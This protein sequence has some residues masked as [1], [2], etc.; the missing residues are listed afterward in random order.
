MTPAVPFEPSAI[1][2]AGRLRPPFHQD[3][4]G[5][6]TKPYSRAVRDLL[7]SDPALAEVYWS[8]SVAGTI[9]G[10]HFQLP[11]T[12]IGKVVFATAGRVRDVVLDLRVGSPAYGTFDVFELAAD[13][14]AVV[15]PR[16]CAHGFEVIDGPACLVYLQDGDFDPDTDAGI[17][18][19]SFG[20]EWSTDQPV[21]S[22]RDQSLPSL[23]QF[24]SPFTWDRT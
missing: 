11:P 20:M 2:G 7:G 22:A 17:R 19:D 12:A 18:W 13:G 23:A 21:V 6:F 8:Q 4:R 16:G 24:D 3:A 9:R 14:S 5:S 1:P 10:M 15:V